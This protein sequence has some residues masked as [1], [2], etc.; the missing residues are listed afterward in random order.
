[1]NKLNSV[2]NFELSR[3]ILNKYKYCLISPSKVKYSDIIDLPEFCKQHDLKYKDLMCAYGHNQKHYQ[4]WVILRNV[5]KRKK[6]KSKICNKC[7][8]EK[9]LDEFYL[10]GNK[11]SEYRNTCKE[12]WDN[13]TKIYKTR[14]YFIKNKTNIN[15]SYKTKYGITYQ[16]KQ[17]LILKQNNKCLCCG[18]DFETIRR[19]QHICIDHDHITGV[20]RG[21]LCNNCNTALGLLH[22]D[23]ERV[24]KLEI[25]IIKHCAKR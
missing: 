1:M 6:I 3:Y 15:Y 8:V 2:D 19:L 4:G 12:C 9:K 10:K 7:G 23:L 5:R 20:I 17:E 14:D 13:Y 11:H 25:Y 21:V 18:V 22:E 16:Q 24:K